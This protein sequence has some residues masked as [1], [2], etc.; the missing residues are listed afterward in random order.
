VDSTVF[1]DPSVTAT[2][3]SVFGLVTP[4]AILVAAAC[5]LFLGSTVRSGRGTWAIVALLAIAG[6]AVATFLAPGSTANLV[7]TVSPIWPDGLT[8]FIRLASLAST[9]VLVFLTWAEVSDALAGEYFGCL[10]LIAGGVNLTAAAN[11]LITLFLALELIS[12]PTY[13][14][15]Y[16]AKSDRSAQ[17]SAIK[18][19]LLSIFSSAFMLFGFSYLAGQTGTTNIPAILNAY[20]GSGE[21][22]LPLLA[23]VAV[24]FIVC[25][26]GF[27]ITAVPFHFYAPDVYQGSTAG[28]AALLAVIPKLAGFAALIR[29]LGLVSPSGGEPSLAADFHVPLFLW[30]LATITMTLGNV[31]ALWQDNLQ[32]I[33]AYSSIAHAGYM[34]VGLTTAPVLAGQSGAPGGVSAILFYLVA[35]AAMTLGAFGVIALLSTAG[36]RVESVDDLAGLSRTHPGLALTMSALLFSLIGLPL[37]A[38]FAGKLMLFFGAL[39][40]P[41]PLYWSLA[42]IM[43]LNAA[44][45]AYYYLRIIGVMYLRGALN[46]L[47]APRCLAGR[48]AVALCLLATLLFGIYPNQLQRM[49]QAAVAEPAVK[50][51]NR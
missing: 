17:E 42:I 5:V 14:L 2:L 22:Q 34:L 26:L 47:G 10:L 33:L 7:P 24:V 18:Y 23:L 12:I 25:G 44:V 21:G 38:G 49:T 30:I 29:L 1:Y 40:V 13:V 27:R 32:R 51:A 20:A 43:A 15:L 36:R 3:L 39:E 28:A 11:D 46:P 41:Q 45:G 9:V 16:L 8:L 50:Q 48:I 4:E 19:F 37:T 35:Y 31:V 6:A